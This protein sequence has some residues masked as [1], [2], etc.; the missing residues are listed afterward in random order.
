MSSWTGSSCRRASEEAPEPEVVDGDA[1]ARVGQRV[2]LRGDAAAVAHHR[3]LREL[4]DEPGRVEAVAVELLEQAV[5]EVVALQL[6]Q[7]G[8]DR[9]DRVEPLGRQA[10]FWAHTACR[11]QRPRSS[12]SP[13]SSATPMNSAG[14][15]RPRSGSSQRTSA[16][17]KAS[18]PPGVDD[19]LEVQE[20]LVAVDRAAQAGARGEALQRRGAVVAPGADPAAPGGLGLVHRGVGVAQERLGVV[21]VLREDADAHRGAEPELVA[22]DP[23]RRPQRLEEALGGRLG[24]ALDVAVD[25]GDQQQELVARGP[26]QQVPGSAPAR[27]APGHVEQDLVPA[28]WPT[29]SLTALKSSRSTDRS[30]TPRPERRALAIA[31]SRCSTSSARLGRSVSAS[32]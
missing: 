9:D 23:R 3:R 14:G 1:H 26:R 24:D 27:Q 2:D 11:T 17:T 13:Y 12:M 29:A 18:P 25:V 31:S 15:T 7:R 30:A 19:R 21:G 20:Q 28:G 6:V 32:W 5:G 22:L 4:H 16:S 8:V 10:A